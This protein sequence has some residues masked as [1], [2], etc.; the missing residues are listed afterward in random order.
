M[1]LEVLPKELALG[2]VL[3][4]QPPALGAM[5]LLLQQGF[6]LH[7]LGRELGR[8]KGV[9][10]GCLPSEPA[11]VGPHL[12]S[13]LGPHRQGNGFQAGCLVAGPQQQ[14]HAQGHHRAQQG[15]EAAVEDVVPVE[16][17]VGWN[18]QE[19]QT[20]QGGHAT[21]RLPAGKPEHRQDQQIGH[22]HP[23]PTGEDR[24]H[25]KGNQAP[26]DGSQ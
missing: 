3:A 14:A 23:H 18:H 25:Q 26:G 9:G 12:D 8:G 15:I 17:R 22:H 19:H 1:V 21:G 16:F 7:Q 24:V 10:P 11:L 2:P 20:H 5:E 6:K 13:H 4:P